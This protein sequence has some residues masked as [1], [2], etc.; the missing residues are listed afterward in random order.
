MTEHTSDRAF[1]QSELARL[2]GRLYGLALRLT[3]DR[4]DAED[5]VSEAIV[6]AWACLGQLKDRGAF[7][8]WITR[9]LIN[10]FISDRRGARPE[11][12]GTVEDAPNDEHFS[13]FEQLH[14]PFL[15]WWSNPEQQLINKLL[16]QDIER[17][18]DSL[19]DEYRVVVIVVEIQGY[20]Y[21]EAA[22]LLEIPVGTVRSRLNRARSRLQRALWRQAADAGLLPGAETKVDLHD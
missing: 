15:L 19:P 13:I 4:D 12:F 5:L 2:T 1:F 14:P 8:K 10:T 21:A 6:R 9:I 17:A 22:E 20:S 18:F 11:A 3:R 7:P 16:R